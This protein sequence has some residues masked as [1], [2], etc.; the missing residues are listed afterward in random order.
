MHT[1]LC[2]VTTDIILAQYKMS[3]IR[4]H[5]NNIITDIKLYSSCMVCYYYGKL[6]YIL[7]MHYDNRI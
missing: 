3:Y 7:G 2:T 1:V 6:L 5:S 4:S